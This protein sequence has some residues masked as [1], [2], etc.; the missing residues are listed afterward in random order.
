MEDSNSIFLSLQC[1]VT[2]GL[3][4]KNDHRF[5][6]T[7]FRGNC[8]HFS[9]CKQYDKRGGRGKETGLEGRR[10]CGCLWKGGGGR[11]IST[12]PINLLHLT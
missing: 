12:E 5:Y 4:L 11:G 10:E 8:A 9:E 7:N 3:A 2:F 1:G 6:A